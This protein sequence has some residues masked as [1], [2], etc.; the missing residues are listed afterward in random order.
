VIK[1]NKIWFFLL[2]GLLLVSPRVSAVINDIVV[3][4]NKRVETPTVLSFVDMK[5]GSKFNEE[6]RE[7]ILKNM[8]A[9]GLFS[10]VVVQEVGS[11]LIITVQENKIINAI[12]FEGNERIKDELMLAELGLRPREVYTPARAQEA[13]QKIVSSLKFNS[14]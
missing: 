6:Q 2:A 4:G 14:F 11:S 5:L 8:Y 12:A 1:G 7:E 13:A 3:E 9:S 10:D